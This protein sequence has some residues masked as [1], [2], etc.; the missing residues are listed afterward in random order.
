M[1]LPSP[2]AL[3]GALSANA[4]DVRDGG[5]IPWSGRSPGRGNS[6]LFQYSCLKNLMDRGV[7]RA[8]VHRVTKSQTWLKWLS[9]HAFLN[10]K[11]Y[12]YFPFCSGH[13]HKNSRVH[14]ISLSGLILKQ[15][16]C[17]VYF[18]N[19]DLINGFSF[20]KYYIWMNHQ[21]L[22]MQTDLI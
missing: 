1:L 12:R 14:R 22:Y 9:K 15:Y 18:R 20:S 19:I 17:G 11:L 7:W 2:V 4:G 8:M 16:L 3:V 10:V 5:W 6:N 13:Q 21:Q